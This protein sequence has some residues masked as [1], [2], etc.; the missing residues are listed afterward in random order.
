LIAIGRFVQRAQKTIPDA[1]KFL[2][3]VSEVGCIARSCR[4][5]RVNGVSQV[6]GIGSGL[7]VSWPH[8]R[9]KYRALPAASSVAGVTVLIAIGRF[10]QRAQ[11]TIRD[12]ALFLFLKSAVG[13]IA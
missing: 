12:S 11:K 8:S 9:Q 10:V 5:A 13:C 1:V 3:L 2:F 6:T 7:I 4:D